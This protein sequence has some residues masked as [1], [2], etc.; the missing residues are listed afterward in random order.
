MKS[1]VYTMLLLAFSISAGARELAEVNLVAALDEPRG[2][3]ID[4]IGY[5]ERARTDRPLQ[6]HTC[7]GYQGSIATDQGVDPEL[8]RRG[9]FRFPHFGVCMLVR[10]ARAHQPIELGE[11]SDDSGQRF[12]FGAHGEIVP[13][14]DT[15]LCITVADER[16]VPGGGG[17]PVHLRRAIRLEHC[18]EQAAQR[19]RW[20]LR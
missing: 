13:E 4:M 18:G 9:R 7:Y 2:Y 14:A 16:G 6:A 20:R 15:T 3:C 8:A 10:R 1:A 17:Q 12:R 5:K 11:C 19:Q